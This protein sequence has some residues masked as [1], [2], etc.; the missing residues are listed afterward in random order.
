MFIFK[1]YNRYYIVN[2]IVVTFLLVYLL[3][4]MYKILHSLYKRRASKAI[5]GKDDDK[6]ITVR[7]G[8]EIELLT[9]LYDKILSCQK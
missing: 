1:F 2:D 4:Y 6:A 9:S 8:G 5:E 7:G 3:K